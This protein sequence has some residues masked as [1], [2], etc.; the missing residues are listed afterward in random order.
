MS[1]EAGLKRAERRAVSREI[2]T[3]KAAC[4]AIDDKISVATLRNI[5]RLG[6]GFE[7]ISG[8]KVG[9]PLSYRFGNRDFVDAVVAWT[10]GNNFGVAHLE[11][12]AFEARQPFT[13]RSVRVPF[14]DEATMFWRGQKSSVALS[15]VSQRGFCVIADD[16][17]PKGSLVTLRCRGRTFEGVESR[18][19][20]F[21]FAGLTLAKPLKIPELAE[22]VS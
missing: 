7:G 12:V 2:R 18:W 4:L 22:M 21:G 20:R 16:I 9:Q 1:N 14:V 13:Y 3:F 11:E 10:E 6:A 15:N 5:S 8:L 17:P 19:S